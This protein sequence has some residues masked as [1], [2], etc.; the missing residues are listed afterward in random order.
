MRFWARNRS[1]MPSRS[2]NAGFTVIELLITVAITAIGFVA[3]L[4]LQV[5]TIRG[6][7]FSTNLAAATNLG[8]H[9][10]A[11]MDVEGV[12]WVGGVPPNTLPML[13]TI[14]GN[15]GFWQVWRC[16][17][18]APDAFMNQTGCDNLVFDVGI[19][20]EIPIRANTRF[21]VQYNLDWANPTR[22]LIDAQVR[23][24]WLRDEAGLWQTFR[25]CPVGT[26]ELPANSVNVQFVTVQGQ[27]MSS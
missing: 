22:T 1:E 26:M 5:A 4:T 24:F 3:L 21:C 11:T 6:L 19:D 9:V 15:E 10:L 23:V 2:G 18:T 13:S 20:S 7:N 17:P 14:N 16:D 27:I 25:D 12:Q 8:E